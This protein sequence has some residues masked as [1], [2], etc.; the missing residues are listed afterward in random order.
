MAL[1]QP[2]RVRVRR[3]IDGARADH[4]EATQQILEQSAGAPGEADVARNLPQLAGQGWTGP[5]I[6][7]ASRQRLA[8]QLQHSRGVE[9][10]AAVDERC[11]CGVIH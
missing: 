8:S 1:T 7:L 5:P 4:T 10:D 3:Q 6:R 9:L 11:R 2:E